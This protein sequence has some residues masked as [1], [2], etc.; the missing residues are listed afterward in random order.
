MVKEEKIED[1]KKMIEELRHKGETYESLGTKAGVSSTSV[2]RLANGEG[3]PRQRTIRKVFETAQYL[4][5]REREK[6]VMKGYTSP[7]SPDKPKNQL[8]EEYQNMMREIEEIMGN[9]TVPLTYKRELIKDVTTIASSIR[10][11]VEE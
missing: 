11:L 7:F 3:E 4:L 2:Y 9:E 5:G 10:N 1:L 8:E 6:G